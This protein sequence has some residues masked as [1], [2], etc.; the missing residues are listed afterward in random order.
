ML[1]AIMMNMPMCEVIMLFV[2]SLREAVITRRIVVSE[3]R[4]DGSPKLLQRAGAPDQRRAPGLATPLP[5]L[6]ALRPIRE[7][8]HGLP[9]GA[10]STSGTECHRA[11]E[12]R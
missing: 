9:C 10:A 8:S 5:A 11:R 3:S 7:A 6:S 2:L 4:P 12:L 1:V